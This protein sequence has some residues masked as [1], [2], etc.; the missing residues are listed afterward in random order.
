M[1]VTI[2]IEDGDTAD[3]IWQSSQNDAKPTYVKGPYIKGP[4]IKGPSLVLPQEDGPDIEVNI[5]QLAAAAEKS[6]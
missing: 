3:T 6:A 2:T 1:K 5:A 4:Y